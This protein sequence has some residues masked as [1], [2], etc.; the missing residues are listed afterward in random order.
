MIKKIETRNGSRLRFQFGLRVVTS[1]HTVQL[2]YFKIYYA[3]I[4]FMVL[5][6]LKTTAGRNTP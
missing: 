2:K 3:N 4:N 5:I 1:F 6:F